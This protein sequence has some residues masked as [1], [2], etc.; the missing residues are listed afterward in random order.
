VF[1]LGCQFLEGRPTSVFP[2][3]ASFIALRLRPEIPK[4][5][6]L[7]FVLSVPSFLEKLNFSLNVQIKCCLPTSA[8]HDP[9]SSLP[10]SLTLTFFFHY[11]D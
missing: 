6:W 10:S 11:W 8:C 2:F 9:P 4:L 7:I 5:L 3:R 1:L